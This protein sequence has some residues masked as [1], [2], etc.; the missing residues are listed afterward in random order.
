MMQATDLRDGDGSS[1]SGRLDWARVRTILVE[2]KMR[3]SALVIVD[4]RGKNSAQM[5]VLTKNSE[6]VEKSGDLFRSAVVSPAC[7]HSSR[8]SSHGSPVGS[9]AA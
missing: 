6:G 7:T 9:A 2:R 4:V 8:N 1:D 3:A 5:A